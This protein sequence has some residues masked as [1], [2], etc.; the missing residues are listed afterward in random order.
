M[1]SSSCRTTTRQRVIA[2]FARASF[3]YAGDDHV[4][5][6]YFLPK[7]GGNYELRG[8]NQ[9]RFHDNNAFMAAIEHRWYVF[10]GLEMALFAD[11]GKTVANKGQIDFSG[12]N[13]SGGIGFRARIQDAVVLRFDVARSRE[14]TR[15]IW[16]H[17]RCLAEAILMTGASS[18]CDG[19]QIGDWTARL[20]RPGLPR[21]CRRTDV[22]PGR[23]ARP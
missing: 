3:A 23:P 18:A 6:F 10:A 7:L 11:A 19:G 8:F 1:A 2:L 17:Q 15:W 22:L 5:P 12:L 16:T 20:G 13:Y 21:A 14:G 4:V 9:Y